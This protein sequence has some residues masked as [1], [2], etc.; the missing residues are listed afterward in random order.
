M[1]NKDL[2][3]IKKYYGE[4]FAKLCREIFP[5]ILEKEGLLSDII[6]SKFAPNSFLYQ[7]IT[8][9]QLFKNI[10]LKSYLDDFKN[11]IYNFVDEK[12]DIIQTNKSIKEL[13]NDAGYDF[14]ECK[15]ENDIQ[16]FKKYYRK[17]EELCTFQ[18]GRLERCYVFWAVKRNVNNIKR[19]DYKKPERQ[20]EYGTSVISIQ[21]TRQGKNLSIKNRYNHHVQNPDATFS[22]NLENI[23]P[24]LTYAFEKEYGFK[25]NQNPF[26]IY[27]FSLD[28]YIL[29]DDG[30]WYRYNYELN[31]IYYCHNN[32]IIDNGKPNQLDK[33]R[34]ILIDYF[35]ID[36]KEKNIKLYDNDLEDSF[37]DSFDNIEK[38]EIHKNK[39][40]KNIIIKINNKEDIIIKINELNQ[41]VGIN[42]NNIKQ[43][44]DKYLNWNITLKELSLPNL[45][46]I[47]DWFMPNNKELT[48]INLPNLTKIGYFFL[49]SNEKIT[50]IQLP[51]LKSIGNYFLN[52]N[53]KM[54]K[55]IRSQLKENK[56]EEIKNSKKR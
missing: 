21:I 40:G 26:N 48:S 46:I 11:Y 56:D 5:T 10:L 55:Y 50:Q 8:Y 32:V 25:I 27:G 3:I 9:H 12:N 18:G 4:D 20:D 13:F 24:G 52:K 23:K 43:I 37:L 42:D 53:E 1:E 17:D 31:N 54:S 47:K 6:L 15:T 38:I 16:S 39:T 41:I 33:S 29:A 51:K 36:L 34:Y 14:Y 45:E 28:N 19:E 49:I 22:N 7:D 2:K 35:I 30:K 44:N